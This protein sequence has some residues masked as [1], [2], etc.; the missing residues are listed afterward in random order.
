[1][2][3]CRKLAAWAGILGVPTAIAGIYGMNFEYMPELHWKF[4]YFVIVGLIALVCAGLYAHFKR[5][6]WL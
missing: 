4:G 6:R 1:M 5:L 2:R 3:V